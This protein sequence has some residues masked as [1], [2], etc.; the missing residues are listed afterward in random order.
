M[1]SS[2]VSIKLTRR[3]A[4][5]TLGAAGATSVAS[6][7]GIPRVFAQDKAPIKIGVVLPLS[8]A[9]AA[10]GTAGAQGITLLAEQTNAKGG[11]LGRQIQVLVEDSQLR[12]QT[13]VVKATK[14]I[15]QDG[16]KFLMGEISG[17]STLALL[18]VAER[19]K[20]V[21]M[22]PYSS[23]EAVTGSRGTRYQFRT[24]SNAFIQA[25][26][27][28][29]C[30]TKTIGKKWGVMAADY[31]YGQDYVNH[32][33]RL[34]P[35]HGGTIVAETFPAL[36]TTDF[37][38]HLQQ[39]STG[40]PDVL[41]MVE[42]GRDATVALNQAVSMGLKSRMAL[43]L[44]VANTEQVTGMQ[45]GVFDGT[46]SFITW[47]PNWPSAESKAFV[48]SYLEKFGAYSEAAGVHYIGMQ[49]LLAGIA[50]A[51]SID[52]DPVIEALEGKEFDTI[53][54]RIKLRAYDHQAVQTY[55]VGKGV[56]GS[57]FPIPV[58]E[59]VQTYAPEVVENSFMPPPDPKVHPVRWR[60]GK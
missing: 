7:A 60:Q 34:L 49:V 52:A 54:G 32:L 18:E 37:V 46:Y 57:E 22:T 58:Y 14:L 5:K 1:A 56:V 9:Y 17:A 53:K 26:V 41:W 12:P 30:M 10:Q 2:N 21:M 28:V 42:Y 24:Y 15:Q 27:A 11:L 20:T 8:G 35:E 23:P 55:F 39:A 31:A 4:L 44:S 59:P 47:Y 25:A 38:S 29:D 3:R 50:N 13:A 16:C 45:A 19:E 6:S 36:G 33:R 48:K 43:G 51:N 40:N